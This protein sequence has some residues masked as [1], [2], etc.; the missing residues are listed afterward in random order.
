MTHATPILS[1]DR[2][3]ALLASRHKRTHALRFPPLSPQSPLAPSHETVTVPGRGTL[4]SFSVIHP[5]PKTGAAP[6]ALGYVDLPGPIRLFGRIAGEGIG[7]GV[8][9]E[10]IA[11][12][13]FGY[14]FNTIQ[15]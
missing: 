7:I 10:L 9:C 8:A 6:F 4:Y 11:D 14:A 15:R 13:E 3:P 1:A 5:N 12:A 2:P